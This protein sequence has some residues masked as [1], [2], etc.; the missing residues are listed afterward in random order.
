MLGALRLPAGV[1]NRTSRKRALAARA[2][3][4]ALALRSGACVT[5][6]CLPRR[7][8]G[9]GRTAHQPLVDAGCKRT[10]V[11]LGIRQQP[12][13]AHRATVVVFVNSRWVPMHRGED[14][15]HGTSI[16][17]IAFENKLIDIA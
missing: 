16:P 6:T 4:P 1:R 9:A 7:W 17:P 3:C 11:C 12:A 8:C 10:A 13:G 5:R 14:F 2:G 15:T